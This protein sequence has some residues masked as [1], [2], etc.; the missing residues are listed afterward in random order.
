MCTLVLALLIVTFTQTAEAE[1]L[2]TDQSYLKMKFEG[3]LKEKISKD[4]KNSIEGDLFGFQTGYPQQDK[5]EIAY[6]MV[7]RLSKP[8]FKKLEKTLFDLKNK[9]K[10]VIAGTKKANRLFTKFDADGGPT[11]IFYFSATKQEMEE[12]ARSRS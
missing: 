6:E 3:F 5:K 1:W 4:C 8:C 2:W 12:V 7:V 9:G 11:I 10:L